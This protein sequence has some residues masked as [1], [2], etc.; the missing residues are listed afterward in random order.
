M[1]RHFKQWWWSVLQ[2]STKRAITSHLNWLSTKQNGET[3]TYD[4]GNPV[5]GLRQAQQYGGIKPLNGI[6]TLYKNV[7]VSDNCLNETICLISINMVWN[8]LTVNDYWIY[9]IWKR[10]YVFIIIFVQQSA[11]AKK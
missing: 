11:N 8:V 5:P 3:T 1:K 9:D 4:V 6:P 10:K 7:T 2:I